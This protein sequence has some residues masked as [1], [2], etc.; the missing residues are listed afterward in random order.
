MKFTAQ[1][2]VRIEVPF[3]YDVPEPEHQ[4]VEEATDLN[5]KPGVVVVNEDELL[6]ARVSAAQ[7]AESELVDEL[8]NALK[9]LGNVKDVLIEEVRSE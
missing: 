9:D 3:E 4:H 7:H 5:P 2:L 1:M 8:H 6:Q